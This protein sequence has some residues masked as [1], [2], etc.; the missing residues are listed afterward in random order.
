MTLFNIAK[1][2]SSRYP[3]ILNFF[4]L[5]PSGKNLAVFEAFETDPHQQ[6]AIIVR[7]DMYIGYMND[8]VSIAMLDNYLQNVI[9]LS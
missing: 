4:Y 3:G 7:P 6:K 9:G 8:L 2:I 5:P 1:W